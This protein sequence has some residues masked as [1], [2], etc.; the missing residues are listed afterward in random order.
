TKT[1]ISATSKDPLK[2]NELPEFTA[3][4]D[5]ETVNSIPFRGEQLTFIAT[6]TL[7]GTIEITW[8][9][10]SPLNKVF[11]EDDNPTY[12]ESDYENILSALEKLESLTNIS[13]VTDKEAADI[14]V[15]TYYS[16]LLARKIS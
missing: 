3:I 7:E 2:Y 13:L 6:K 9:D 10:S 12:I 1:K 15:Q 8:V 11:L 16:I 5:G 14:N 4:V